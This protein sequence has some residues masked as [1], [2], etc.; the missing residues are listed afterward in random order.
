M[1]V[2][3]KNETA[4]VVF[5]LLSLEL[6]MQQSSCEALGE[7]SSEGRTRRKDASTSWV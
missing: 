5:I 7:G 4:A 6:H 3:K 1:K 2:T